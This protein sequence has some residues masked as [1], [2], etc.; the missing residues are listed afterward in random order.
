[1]ISIIVSLGI[2]LNWLSIFFSYKKLNNLDIHQPIATGGFPLKIFSY[3]FPPMGHDW[4]PAKAWPV[5]F[6]NLIIWTAVIAVIFLIFN[7][8]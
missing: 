8:K 6:L 5:F 4:P 7:K 3:P 2:I 1:M